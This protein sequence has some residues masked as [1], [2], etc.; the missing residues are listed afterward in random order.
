MVST[1]LLQRLKQLLIPSSWIP[2]D[3]TRIT[4]LPL[5]S[6]QMPR[7]LAVVDRLDDM[8]I[9]G[10]EDGHFICFEGEELFDLVVEAVEESVTDMV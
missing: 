1:L 9:C 3:E 8:S 5:A 2:V 10:G 7:T 6:D 4:S